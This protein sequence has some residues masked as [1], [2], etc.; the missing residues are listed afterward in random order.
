M[1]ALQITE[2]RPL[3]YIIGHYGKDIHKQKW[4]VN[5]YLKYVLL[6]LFRCLHV[7]VR[8]S[9]LSTRR[10]SRQEN[11]WFCVSLEKPTGNTADSQSSLVPRTS[12]PLVL[13]SDQEGGGTRLSQNVV[14]LGAVISS[15]KVLQ[16]TS[17]G[18]S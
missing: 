8:G 13:A 5:K 11:S 17:L 9:V 6:S 16:F 1:C 14:D 12:T 2:R 3:L 7:R 10:S 4:N 18:I 15:C